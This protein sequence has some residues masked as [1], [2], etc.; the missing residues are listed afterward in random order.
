VGKFAL[1]IGVSESREVDL[2]GLPS[3]LKD[4]QAMQEVLQN[5]DLG[6]F[7]SVERLP[8]PS[9]Q[10]MEEAIETLFAN[11]KKNDLLLFYF[12]G[13]GITDERGRLYLVTPET[14]KERG[15]L[16]RT[17]AV[18]AT[19]LHENMS[20]S[21]SKHQ[22]LILDCCFSGAISEGLT[23]K[24]VNSV[25]IQRELG[26]EGRAI[27]TS[28][29]SVQ[30]SFHIQGYDL[31]IYTH[32]LID[33]IQTGAANLDGDDFISMDE[34]HE[35][36]KKRLEQEAPLMTP[37]FFPVK[38][39]YKIRLI[40][41]PINSKRVNVPIFIG[42][43]QDIA[44][45]ETFVN[46]G[47]R[48]ILILSDGG[49]GKT[50]LAQQ[51]LKA[52]KFDLLLECYLGINPDQVPLL[53][54]WLGI[55]LIQLDQKLEGE[56]KKPEPIMLQQLKQYLRETKLRVGIIVDNLDTI[57]KNSKFT[58]KDDPYRYLLLTL[59][60]LSTKVTTII[61]SRE[62]LNESG[63][64]YQLYRL[65]GLEENAWKHFF[66][67]NDIH[68]FSPHNIH[69]MHRTCSGNAEVMHI[70]KSIVQA[71][72]G[73]DVNIFW[74]NNKKDFLVESAASD[75][76]E[77]QFNKI[78]QNNPAA[79]KLLCR[80]GFDFPNR[81]PLAEDLISKLLWDIPQKDHKKT[82]IFLRDRSLV[83]TIIKNKDEQ[84][85]LDPMIQA[86]S[87]RRLEHRELQ[88]ISQRIV[89]TEE[90]I[91]LPEEVDNSIFRFNL[92]S[93]SFNE[94][95]LIILPVMIESSSRKQ[96]FDL[97]LDTGAQISFLSKFLAEIIDLETMGAV[98]VQGVGING[99]G[100]FNRGV[101]KNIQIGEISLGNTEVVF[102][103][104][105]TKFS[106]YNILGI[107]GS[108]TLQNVCL[109]IDYPKKILEISV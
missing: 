33:G 3:A 47:A 51:Y 84:Y 4:I 89:T 27:L 98:Y 75:L 49:V 56:S 19:L 91:L 6:G 14:R 82:T 2:P 109:K 66:E 21:V 53:E 79:Y 44:A 17:T 71:D 16:R 74:E 23:G 67:L 81:P 87:L 62:P 38:E 90:F 61:T 48:S 52:Q 9:R 94:L 45:I 13:H 99:T 43:E 34:L 35:Y 42:R 80:M 10:V 96:V 107:L 77:R 1:L 69:E 18:A 70:I 46:Q 31:S 37:Q 25:D 106:K 40:R 58:Q 50:T 24:S 92:D 29:N 59:G 5:P 102:G 39:G 65:E 93:P 101:V 60:D 26:G 103:D 72:Y 55:W 15:N 76:I 104:L 68:N 78:Q 95:G 28:S 57:L 73:G 12:S 108:K 85:Y 22:V 41:S 97:L 11:R 54:Y 105:P 8:N 88:E 7:D 86:E 36:I 63:I 64:R 100:N 30:K 32:F 83:K 20:S